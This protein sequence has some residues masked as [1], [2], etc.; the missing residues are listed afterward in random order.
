MSRIRIPSDPRHFRISGS[1]SKVVLH[2]HPDPFKIIQTQFNRTVQVWPLMIVYRHSYSIWSVQ[3][4]TLQVMT[5]TVR[6]LQV[7]KNYEIKRGWKSCDIVP[8]SHNWNLIQLISFYIIIFSM[9]TT[10]ALTL[11]E[12]LLDF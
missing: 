7:K 6:Q 2:L 4:W 9:T 10:K 8:L 5:V 1:G 11:I 3:V 12:K